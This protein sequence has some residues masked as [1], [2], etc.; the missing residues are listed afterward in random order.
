[1]WYRVERVT[2]WIQL[3]IQNMDREQ[4]MVISVIAVVLGALLLR[5]F[6]S[7]TDY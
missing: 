3:A 2:S 6:G 1:M 4:W 7:R 5:G